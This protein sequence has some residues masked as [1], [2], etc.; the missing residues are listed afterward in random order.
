MSY[1]VKWMGSFGV[2]AIGTCLFYKGASTGG[3]VVKLIFIQLQYN[4]SHHDY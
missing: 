1:V 4:H 2:I 3:F